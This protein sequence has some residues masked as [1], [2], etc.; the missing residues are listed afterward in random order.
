[1]TGFVPLLAVVPVGD[2]R[3][4]GL[5]FDGSNGGL[6]VALGKPLPGGFCWAFVGR[7]APAWFAA[8]FEGVEPLAFVAW[9]LL[10]WVLLGWV[11]LACCSAAAASRSR[12]RLFFG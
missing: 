11:R 5:A 7:G 10:G 8:D 6:A 1:M 2:R 4:G 3:D 12:K 9:V